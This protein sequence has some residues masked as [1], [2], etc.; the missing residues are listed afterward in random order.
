MVMITLL[1]LVMN[2]L[3]LLQLPQ[4]KIQMM[5]MIHELQQH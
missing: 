5:H 4:E 2:W 1:L 3:L